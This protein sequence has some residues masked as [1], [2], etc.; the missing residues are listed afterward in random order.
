M[1]PLYKN[2]Y[3][4]FEPVETTMRKEV[5][6]KKNRNEPIRANIYNTYIYMYFYIYVCIYIHIYRSATKKLPI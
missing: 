3:R 5:R 1:Y 6:K 2:D 4:I